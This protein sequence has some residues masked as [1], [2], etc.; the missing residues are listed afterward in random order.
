M[1]VY[2]D[3]TR[4]DY[5]GLPDT[6]AKLLEESEVCLQEVTERFML[7][8]Y[9]QMLHGMAALAPLKDIEDLTRAAELKSELWNGMVSA[10][11][12]CCIATN[13]LWHTLLLN[14]TACGA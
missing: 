8:V 12:A 2:Q 5:T 9:E 3:H 7:P 11:G 6:T 4:V 13:H 10:C 1:V 14:P